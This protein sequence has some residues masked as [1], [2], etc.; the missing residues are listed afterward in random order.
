MNSDI[1]SDTLC[2]D[3]SSDTNYS[4]ASNSFRSVLWSDLEG[5]IS[6]GL[7]RVDAAA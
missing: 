2:S 4:D 6:P 1:C 3:I 5:L 7:I